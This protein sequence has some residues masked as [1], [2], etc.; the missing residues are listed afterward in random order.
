[1]EISKECAPVVD[2]YFADEKRMLLELSSRGFSAQVIYDIGGSTG[3]WSDSI[4]TV[5]RG[6]EFHLFEPLSQMVD[7]YQ[8]DLEGRLRRLP[9]LHLHAIALGD[10]NGLAE[11]FISEDGWG[12][13]LHDRG[14]IPEVK[15]RVQIPIFR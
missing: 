2:N 10:H 15:E 9:N 11:M 3:F 6:A 12:S 8:R 14:A 7:F 4:A 5:A 13:S 1:M